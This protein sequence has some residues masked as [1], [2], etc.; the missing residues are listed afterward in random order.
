MRN[1][2]N[3][4][5]NGQQAR[6]AFYGQGTTLYPSNYPLPPPPPPRDGYMSGPPGTIR[7]SNYIP[8]DDWSQTSNGSGY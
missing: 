7:T 5:Q 8:A 1:R 2:S 6:Q 3:Q 4:N